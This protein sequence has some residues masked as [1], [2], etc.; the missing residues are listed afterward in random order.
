[1]RSKDR[2]LTLEAKNGTVNVWLFEQDAHVIAEIAGG[3]IVRAVDNDIKRRRQ[4]HGDFTVEQLV[5]NLDFDFGIDVRK[6]CFCRDDL[7]FPYVRGAVQQ[8]PLKIRS[9]DDIRI[10]DSQLA[11][12]GRSQIHGDGR[13]E[14]AGTDAK[15]TGCFELELSILPELWDRQ[16]AGVA[17]KFG[18]T[19]ITRRHPGQEFPLS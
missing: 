17:L 4:F 6:A 11:D 14:T 19:E 8:L 12:T 13:A 2:R 18:G 7:L 3:K 1:M 5:V 15:D 16:V 10:D 9:I